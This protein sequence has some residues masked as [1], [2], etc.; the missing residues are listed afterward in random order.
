MTSIMSN[1]ITII[2]KVIVMKVKLGY[3]SL[4]LSLPPF[5]TLNY[6]NYQKLADKGLDKLDQVIIYNFHNLR[7]IL[8]YN[9]ANEVFFYRL[10][11][12]LIH[13]ATH[14]KVTFDYIKKYQK[15]WLEIGIL[16]KKY[17]IRTDTHPDQYCVLNSPSKETVKSSIEILKY[18]QNIFKAMKIDGKVILHI[19]G[20][21]SSKEEAIKRFIS[22]FKKLD[23]SLQNIIMLENDDKVFNVKDVLEVCEELKIPMVLDYHH[24]ICNNENED[25]RDYLPRILNTWKGKLIPKMHFSSPKSIKEKRSHSEYINS[26]DF[27]DFLEILKKYTKEVDIMLECKAKD[28]ALFRLIREIKYKTNYKFINQTT[29]ILQ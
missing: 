9:Y 2:I 27:I 28:E 15:H 1:E 29:F 19:G 12:N 26:A 6:T 5:K 7:E 17:Q 11:H 8:K 18:N 23:K 16:I 3:V 20:K 24:Y 4:S 14:P 10:N 21:Y 13:L 22:N 25:I